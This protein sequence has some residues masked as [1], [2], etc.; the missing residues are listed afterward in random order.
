MIRVTAF[1]LLI[2]ALLSGCNADAVNPP[3]PSMEEKPFEENSEETKEVSSILDPG[4]ENQGSDWVMVPVGEDSGNG[5]DKQQS[6]GDVLLNQEQ[7]VKLFLDA[8]EQ[9]DLEK[10]NML[11]FQPLEE[12]FR[13]SH[14]N[15]A[16]YRYLD[17]GDLAGF[18]RDAIV[19][20][21][22]YSIDTFD[23]AKIENLLPNGDRLK[24]S[25]GDYLNL[26]VMLV[27]DRNMW[28]LKSMEA[29][30]SGFEEAVP[31]DWDTL[32]QL[33]LADIK[34]MDGDGRYE[35][36][37]MGFRGEWEG[38]GPEPTSA[39]G[40][41][42]FSGMRINSLYFKDM[43][44]RLQDDRVVTE[45]GMGR[46]LEGQPAALVLIEKT[47]QD[48][49]AVVEGPDTDYFV[50]LYNLADRELKK[51][52]DIDWK[53]A[54]SDVLG[55]RIVPEWVE[56][57]GVKR[58]KEGTAESVVLRVGLR[59]R[60]DQDDSYQTNEGIFILSHNGVEWVTDWYHAG[61]FGEYHT[62][63]FEEPV[64]VDGAATLYYVED[65]PY[66]EG[67]G[68]GVFEVYHRNGKWS[69]ERIF[70]EKLNIKAAGDMDG[71]GEAEFL[72]FDGLKLKVHSKDGKVLWDAGLP[73]ETKD[74]PFSWL[75][76][77]D[78]KQW[79]VAALHTGDYVNMSSGIF[80]WEGGDYRLLNTWQSEALGS[81]GVTAMFVR[82]IDNDGKT[83]ILANYT[84]DYLVWGQ[85]FKV[86][87]P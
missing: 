84:D 58:M 44:D 47:A 18:V 65:I 8:W 35:L 70:R 56:L 43:Y 72:V 10:M 49:M 26:D 52:G 81:D 3:E 31:G 33:V 45:G 48:N 46:V 62:V 21:K 71:D 50:S 24:V 67:E 68:G 66:D 83:E 11:T 61:T 5:R 59:D 30:I 1:L 23:N 78:G 7:A 77:V 76:S 85:F 42:S 53:G 82:D 14:M 9:N 87:E 55:N 86:F 79:V 37:A 28:K 17:T 19:K 29:N 2:I 38:I 34:D 6:S 25:I 74:V 51:V 73:G 13:Q 4:K 60:A 64:N 12:F 39:I 63:I 40:I 32:D 16:A 15:F 27:L 57:L 36:L 80:I 69:G 75:G 20:L 41:Y 22:E 54:V